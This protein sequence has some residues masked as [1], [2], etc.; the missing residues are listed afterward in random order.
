MIETN[1]SV[2]VGRYHSAEVRETLRQTLS[3]MQPGQ[4][5]LWPE[6]KYVY[7]AARQVG[8]KIKTRKVDGCGYRVWRVR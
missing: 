2:P 3:A 6:N 7:L 8:V 1:Q 4:S 5:F